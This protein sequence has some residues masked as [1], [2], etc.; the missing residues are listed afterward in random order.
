MFDFQT[1]DYD[2]LDNSQL[3][4]LADYWMRQYLLSK[5]DSRTGMYK[6]PIK[7]KWYSAGYME[8]AHYID[9]ANPCTRYDLDN[10]HLISRDSNSFDAQ[11]QVEGHKSKH[12]KEYEE[13]LGKEKVEELKEKSKQFCL[14][15]AGDY[16]NIIKNF[17]N[18]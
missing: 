7:N 17:R 5:T 18:V 6:C 1:E 10:C 15:Y 16:I 13:F 3:K 11:V 4:K 2:S 8:V 9:R 14:H 12:H